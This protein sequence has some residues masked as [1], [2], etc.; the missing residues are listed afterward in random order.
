MMLHKGKFV[1]SAL[2][3]ELFGTLKI[4]LFVSFGTDAC[5]K[6]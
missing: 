4:A 3:L 5:C 2:L 1:C 6:C